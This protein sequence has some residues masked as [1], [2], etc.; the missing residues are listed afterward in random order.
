MRN[1]TG[2]ASTWG[3]EYAPDAL[4]VVG[5]TQPSAILDHADKWGGFRWSPVNP[6]ELAMRQYDP[7]PDDV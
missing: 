4:I 7:M 2:L 5:V 6:H 3:A 1:T